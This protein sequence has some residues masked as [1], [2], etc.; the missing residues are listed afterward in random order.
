MAGA[1]F[2]KETIKWFRKHP[3]KQT[4]LRMCEKC[5]KFYKPS[6]G[7]K[8]KQNNRRADDGLSGSDI[9]HESNGR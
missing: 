1:E 8:C 9:L 5:G 6:L 4:T 7:H 3:E 2:D